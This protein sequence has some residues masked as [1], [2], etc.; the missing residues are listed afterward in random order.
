MNKRLFWAWKDEGLAMTTTSN[1]ASRLFDGLLR[2]Y[3]SW[4]DCEH[5]GGIENTISALQKADSD[6]RLAMTTTSNEAFRLFGGLLRQYVS[7]ADCEHLGGI[8]NTIS[9]LQKADS[10]ASK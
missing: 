10:D 5:L 9:A 6:A 3:V 7:W 8:E 1:E 2:Q 4:A